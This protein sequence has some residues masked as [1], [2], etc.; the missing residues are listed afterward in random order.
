MNEQSINEQTD[1][2]D[3]FDDSQAIA[4]DET[5]QTIVKYW[6]LINT[7]RAQRDRLGRT[8]RARYLSVAITDLETS[9]LRYQGSCSEIY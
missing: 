4:N 7:L 5:E 6:E 3:P 1:S 2:G 9:M 8:E